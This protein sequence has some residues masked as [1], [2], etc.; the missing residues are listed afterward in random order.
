M[1]DGGKVVHQHPLNAPIYYSFVQDGLKQNLIFNYVAIH[2]RA[3]K[4]YVFH[5]VRKIALISLF[6]KKI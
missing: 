3:K 2:Y 5:N 4:S 6:G 1:F